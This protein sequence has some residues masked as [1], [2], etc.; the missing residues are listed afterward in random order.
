M[1]RL[2]LLFLLSISLNASAAIDE[3]FWA[4]LKQGGN[5][6]LMRHAQT[7]PG[8][9]DPRGFRLGDCST[10][11]NLSAEGR[12]DAMRIGAAFRARAIAVADVLSSRWC[13]CVDT[14]TIAFGKVRPAT[15]L[16]SV[17]ND[18]ERSGEDKHTELYKF[19]AQRPAAA[20]NLVLVTHALNISALTGV[21]VA[22]GEMPIVRL[23]GPRTLTV[24]GRATP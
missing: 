7:V 12:A 10:Q 22:S 19:L 1:T 23:D 5:I 8:V 18:S 17:F 15:M 9:G 13:R 11:R 3:A 16:D 6:V 2:L 24:L 20:G 21:S 4:Q 14:A